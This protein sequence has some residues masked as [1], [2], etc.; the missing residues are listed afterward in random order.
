MTAF[1]LKIDY[2]TSLFA[3]LGEQLREYPKQ[4]CY[5]YLKASRYGDL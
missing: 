2:E 1:N 5:N 3:F 4:A